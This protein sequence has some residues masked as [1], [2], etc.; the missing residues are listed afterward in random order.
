MVRSEYSNVLCRLDVAAKFQEA[1]HIYQTGETYEAIDERRTRVDSSCILFGKYLWGELRICIGKTSSK[2][3]PSS[4]K[5]RHILPA[6][7]QCIPSTS[8]DCSN[9]HMISKISTTSEAKATQL[10]CGVLYMHSQS[11]ATL[12]VLQICVIGQ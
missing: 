1:C 6:G 12:L 7:H 10:V 4:L 2:L 9:E 8:D 5:A 3:F 11:R